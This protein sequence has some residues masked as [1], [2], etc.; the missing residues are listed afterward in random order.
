MKL[1]IFSLIIVSILF[2]AGCQ[3]TVGKPTPSQ[4]KYLQTNV[5]CSDPDAKFNYTLDPNSKYY[6]K[7]TVSYTLRGEVISNVDVC[8]IADNYYNPG[9]EVQ[10]C[11]GGT[12]DCIDI[13]VDYFVKEYYC[14]GV[15]DIKSEFFPCEYGC[16]NG[17]CLKRKGCTEYTNPPTCTRDPLCAWQYKKGQITGLTN[18]YE[19]IYQCTEYNGIKDACI[20]DPDCNWY[21]ATQQCAKK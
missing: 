13:G 16:S 6:K 5:R 1:V 8:V 9:I 10:D 19:C 14:D 18:E 20:R 11:A 21:E 17:E 2:I 7:T 4:Q 3:E 12:Q 15:Y